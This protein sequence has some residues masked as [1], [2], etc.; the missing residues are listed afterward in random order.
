[1]KKKTV[2]PRQSNLPHSASITVNKDAAGNRT[3][4]LNSSI[5]NKS[6]G[7]KRKFKYLISRGEN[8]YETKALEAA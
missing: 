4:T 1:M 7:M 3:E 6:T 2:T 8:H 5:C